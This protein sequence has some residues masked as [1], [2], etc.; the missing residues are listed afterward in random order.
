MSLTFQSPSRAFP[1]VSPGKPG[2]RGSDLPEPFKGT[3]GHSHA[4]RGDRTADINSLRGSASCPSR[5]TRPAKRWEAQATEA[6][7]RSPG[8]S[9]PAGP[10]TRRCRDISSR[11]TRAAPVI[12]S[13]FLRP[14]SGGW[15]GRS[16]KMG[17]RSSS[18]LVLA[19]RFTFPS[20]RPLTRVYR[21]DQN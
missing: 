15:M 8:N 20:P 16:R 14:G 17:L 9:F 21:I 19:P 2:V 3:A 4:R 13:V 5:A 1:R 10:T 18:H 6:V 11:Q 7:M 12:Q